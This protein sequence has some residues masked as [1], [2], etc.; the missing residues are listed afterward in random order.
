MQILF[1][2]DDEYWFNIIIKRIIN[3]NYTHNSDWN[4]EQLANP[5]ISVALYVISLPRNTLP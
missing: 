1:A 2:V 5:V 3:L 4:I